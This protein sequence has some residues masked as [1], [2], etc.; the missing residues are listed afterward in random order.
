MPRGDDCAV[1]VAGRAVV[2][3]VR[4]DVTGLPLGVVGLLENMQ[5]APVGTPFGQF[6]EI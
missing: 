6:S 5:L 1:V 3:I 2:E 4:A